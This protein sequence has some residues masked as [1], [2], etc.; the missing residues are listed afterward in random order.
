MLD[1]IWFCFL[2]VVVWLVFVYGVGCVVCRVGLVGGVWMCLRFVGFFLLWWFFIVWGLFFGWCLEFFLVFVG[3]FVFLVVG[4]GF[5]VVCLGCYLCGGGL[6]GLFGCVV[7]FGW[8]GSGLVCFYG[9]VWLGVKLEG[10]FGMFLGMG[11]DVWGVFLDSCGLIV[12]L[13]WW[14]GYFGLFFVVVFFM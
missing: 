7:F 10:V 4:V 14:F 11:F 12:F 9:L 2:V 3:C 1:F 5:V 6:G 13:L 8:L